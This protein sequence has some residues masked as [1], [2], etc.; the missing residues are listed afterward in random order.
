MINGT[1][2]ALADYE[3]RYNRVSN[4]LRSKVQ[5]NETLSFTVKEL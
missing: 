5:E 4:D 3:A 2:R 1:E